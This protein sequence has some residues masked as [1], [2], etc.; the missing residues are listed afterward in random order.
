MR[1]LAYHCTRR[2]ITDC[3]HER[4]TRRGHGSKFNQPRKY[5]IVHHHV[6][7]PERVCSWNSVFYV[8]QHCVFIFLFIYRHLLY[9][10]FWKR[11][12][13][14]STVFGEN[15]GCARNVAEEEKKN[16]RYRHAVTGCSIEIQEEDAILY[17]LDLRVLVSITFL[18]VKMQNLQEKHEAVNFMNK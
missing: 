12:K 15:W 5:S 3:S 9:T 4:W 6:V 10:I 13:K 18:S 8:R 17:F 7:P 16:L 14:E 11:K 1:R 2:H